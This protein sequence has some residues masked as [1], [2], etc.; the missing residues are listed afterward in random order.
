M[1]AGLRGLKVVDLG[2]GMAAALV[3]KYLA[4]AGATVT[5]VE[6]PGGDPFYRH[7]PAYEVWR[8][9]AQIDTEASR[10]E[11]A[12]A[13]RLADADVC[14]MGGED[15]P[16]AAGW[17]RDAAE[18]SWRRGRCGKRRTTSGRSFGATWRWMWRRARGRCGDRAASGGRRGHEPG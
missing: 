14:I 5:R 6:P 3:A 9:G 15:H 17:R 13:L 11:A 2:L 12:L 8:R 16:A 4:E 18:R 1:T 7:Y 10:A